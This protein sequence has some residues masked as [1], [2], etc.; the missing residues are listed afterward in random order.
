MSHAHLFFIIVHA[1]G[2][3]YLLLC[4]KIGES[5]EKS[6]LLFLFCVEWKVVELKGIDIPIIL[7]A[8]IYMLA[9]RG[10][11]RLPRT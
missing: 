8:S 3:S 4:I 6:M 1:D 9:H 5:I 7:G 11:F 10:S 2:A